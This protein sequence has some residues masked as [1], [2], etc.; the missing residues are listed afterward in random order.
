MLQCRSDSKVHFAVLVSLLAIASPS[1]AQTESVSAQL[2]E[3]RARLHTYD[4]GPEGTTRVIESLGSLA[5][6]APEPVASEA[7]FLRAVAT[8]DI[9]LIARRRRDAALGERVA[10]A[11]GVTPRELDPALRSEL[12]T[13]R[14]EPFAATIDDV[15]AALAPAA[16]LEIPPHDPEHTRRQAVFFTRV[17]DQLLRATD[18]TEVLAALAADPCG[19]IE[20]E[21]PSPYRAFGPRG[22]RALAAMS[23]LHELLR[24]VEHTATLGDPFSAALAREVLVDALL[25]RSITLAPRDWAQRVRSVPVPERSSPLDVDA[26]IVVGRGVVRA[27]WVPEVNWDAQGRARIVSDGS[28]LDSGEDAIPLS[29]DADSSVRPIRTLEA[30]LTRRVLGAACIAL[31]VEPG[32]ETHVLWRILASLDHARIRPAALAVAATDGTVRGVTFEAVS[33]DLGS[34]GVFVRLGGFSAW[35]PG[36]RVTLPRQRVGN[37]WEFDF[38]GVELATRARVGRALTIRSMGTVAADLVLRVALHLVSGSR[39]LR[40][41]VPYLEQDEDGLEI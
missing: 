22:R 12:G 39:Q 37:S 6:I 10:R 31:V 27:G 17:F 32:V 15:V 35:Q 23:S 24:S 1:A 8:A 13:L 2:A 14:H 20:V 7:R 41:I 11:Y 26:A 38:A 25:L 3:L 30:Y 21:C 4:L 5:A 28:M 40:L 34:V 29:I 9:L 19:R 33:E 36:R 18:A 16:R